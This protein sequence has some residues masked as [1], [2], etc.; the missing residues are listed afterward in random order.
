MP[1]RRRCCLSEALSTKVGV[2]AVE[3]S[4]VN[5]IIQMAVVKNEADHVPRLFA[6][7]EGS[8]PIIRG[9]LVRIIRIKCGPPIDAKICWMVAILQD[10]VINIRSD[11]CLQEY[12]KFAV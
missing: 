10:S 8:I 6:R 2:H 5:V 9:N 1:V 7:T 12:S 11:A 4:G 3:G